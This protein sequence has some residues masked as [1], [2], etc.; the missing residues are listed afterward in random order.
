[1]NKRLASHKAEQNIATKKF[2][3]LK[4]I[5]FEKYETRKEAENR[6]IQLKK[7]SRAKKKA[8]I[9]GD[10]DLLIKLSKS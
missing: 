3:E 9:E 7:W 1:M 5:Y 4:L 8:L 10:I 6:E 2:S